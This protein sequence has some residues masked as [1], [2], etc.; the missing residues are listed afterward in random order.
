MSYPLIRLTK[1][2]ECRRSTDEIPGSRC[3]QEARR[4]KQPIARAEGDQG[5]S[6]YPPRAKR[7]SELRPTF[8]SL[9]WA[10]RRE[11]NS[12]EWSR[13]HERKVMLQH[14][15]NPLQASSSRYAGSRYKR[16]C[17]HLFLNSG[18]Q[19]NQ[20]SVSYFVQNYQQNL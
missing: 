14:Q 2:S 20:T 15:H 13:Q 7:V 3:S 6:K 1:E 19:C 17:K 4:G 16:A 5:A 18:A 8:L 9:S 10:D 11:N 12:G